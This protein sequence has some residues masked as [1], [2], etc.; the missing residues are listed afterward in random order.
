MWPL[1]VTFDEDR[2][3]CSISTQPADADCRFDK[4]LDDRQVWIG[5]VNHTELPP[6]SVLHFA[7][8]GLINSPY[9]E[10]TDS[11][12][13]TTM[14]RAGYL[15]DRA[16]NGLTVENDCNWPCLEC[17]SSDKSKCLACLS[18]SSHT[19]HHEDSCLDACPDGWYSA[20]LQCHRCSD[21]CKTCSGSAS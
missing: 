16:D 6:G 14:T 20:H 17:D 4:T 2:F 13:V 5:N 12:V 21:D 1:Q 15:I 18:T 9:A 19:I 8:F 7:V 11:F 10:A 3:G